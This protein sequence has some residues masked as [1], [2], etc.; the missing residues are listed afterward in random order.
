MT[1]GG[2]GGHVAGRAWVESVGGRAACTQLRGGGA[3][4][5]RAGEPRSVTDPANR[6]FLDS[7]ARGEC[8]AELEPSQREQARGCSTLC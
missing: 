5:G 2:T 1:S 3:L 6:P 7:V 4:R 8:P